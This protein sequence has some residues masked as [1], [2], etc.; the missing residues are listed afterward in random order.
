V[1]VSRVQAK[2]EHAGGPRCI[3]NERG[4]GYRLVRQPAT[5][6]DSCMI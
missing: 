2:I 1:I 4:I 5:A 3:E 6:H